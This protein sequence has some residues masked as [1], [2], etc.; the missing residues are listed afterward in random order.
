M[1]RKTKIVMVPE[2]FGRDSEPK[3]KVFLLTE[4]PAARA[5]KWALRALLAFNRSDRNL[6]LLDADKL[7]GAGMEGIF[8]IGIQVFL[9]GGMKSEEVQPILDELLD[10]VQMI[11]DPDKKDIA[12]GLPVASAIVSGDDI[13]EVKTRFWLRSEVLRLHSGFSPGD[14]L[15]ILIS[16]IMTK[17]ASPITKTSPP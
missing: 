10:C 2:G 1:G 3:R 7:I 11:R 16:A 13:E 9:S 8:R 6:G 5:E 12:T 15:S 4:W 14:A 17:E